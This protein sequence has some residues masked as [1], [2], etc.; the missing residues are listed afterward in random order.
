[1]KM[2][3]FKPVYKA[4]RWGLLLAHIF[5]FACAE[6]VDL[7]GT[8]SGPR[9]LSVTPLRGAAG[10]EVI[11]L[12]K[13]F[14]PEMEKNLVKFNGV[15]GAIVSASSD[16][17]TAIVPAHAGTGLIELVALNKATEGPIFTFLETPIISRTDPSSGQPGTEVKLYGK[18][19]DNN[20]ENNIVKFGEYTALVSS[21]IA[22]TIINTIVPENAITGTITVTVNDVT[23][24]GPIFIVPGTINDKLPEISRYNPNSGYAGDEIEIHGNNFSAVTNENLVQFNGKTAVITSATITLIKAIVP[25]GVG[26]GPVTVKVNEQYATGPVFTYLT[27]TPE[28]ID[29]TPKSGPIGTTVPI[30]GKNFGNNQGA[31]QVKFNGINAVLND[32]DD[33]KLTVIVP[34]M[35]TTGKISVSVNGSVTTSTDNFTVTKVD[36]PIITTNLSILRVRDNVYIHGTNLSAESDENVVKI[37]DFALDVTYATTSLIVVH[38]TDGASSGVLTITVNGVKAEFAGSGGKTEKDVQVIQWAEA[39]DLKEGRYG[40]TATLLGNGKVLVAGG[41]N[42]NNYLNSVEIFDPVSNMWSHAGYLHLERAQHTANLLPDGKVL[43]IG[44]FSP[45]GVLKQCEIFDPATGISNLTENMNTPRALHSAV[46]LDNGKVM[47][48]SGTNGV[49]NINFGAP[50][51]VNSSELYDPTQ[52]SWTNLSSFNAGLLP[53]IPLFSKNQYSKAITL[54]DGKVFFA[55]FIQGQTGLL[56]SYCQIYNPTS[57][58]W[59]T[60]AKFP[61][62]TLSTIDLTLLKNGDVFLG[63]IAES[64]SYYVYKPASNSWTTLGNNIQFSTNAFTSTVLNDGKLLIAGG[65]NVAGPRHFSYTL[66]PTNGLQNLGIGNIINRQWHTATKL[67]DGTVLI[68]GGLGEL[69]RSLTKCEIFVPE[70]K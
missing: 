62:T 16:K 45:I 47:V 35:A 42:S 25:E 23:G 55:G 61:M 43:F 49:N 22:D 3:Y 46:M 15:D 33:T 51:L 7:T 52:N 11:I 56:E 29:F 65:Y 28:I 64:G 21:V 57:N 2:V 26:S 69:S 6:V 4:P 12:G 5:L 39:A 30:S 44:G 19:F 1:M 60:A 68:T 32:F 37:D 66:D 53:T 31:I 8:E 20:A 63:S 38:V 36:P 24:I 13:D 54:A 67:N 58:T 50:M 9:I 48:I 40:H 27:K 10:T 41:I 70:I 17:I 34:N 18:H 14:H 59:S